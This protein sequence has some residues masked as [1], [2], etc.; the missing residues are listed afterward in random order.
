MM[1]DFDLSRFVSPPQ[2]QPAV[3]T[4]CS[5]AAPSGS[6]Q[7][8]SNASPVVASYQPGYQARGSKVP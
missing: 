2:R 3:R 8:G 7:F 6:P 1:G 5:R 4:A